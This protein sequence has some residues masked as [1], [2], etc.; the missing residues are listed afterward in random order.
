MRRYV[1]SIAIGLVC[2]SHGLFDLDGN[3]TVESPVLSLSLNLAFSCLLFA[4]VLAMAVIDLRKLI[5]PDRLNLLMAGGGLGHAIATGQPD[6]V[7]ALAG[8]LA[9]FAIL[10]VTGV[11]FQ[12]YRGI[13]GLGFGDV[14]F[15]G[16]AGFWIGS[17]KIAPMLLVASCSALAFVAIRSAREKKIDL[18]S[19]LPFGPFLGFGTAVCWLINIASGS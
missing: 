15:A 7:Q 4:V 14:K 3:M 11:L 16:A 18:S 6:L 13:D 8:A 12:R 2:A 10:G 17:E 9:G 5:L 1:L 19:R